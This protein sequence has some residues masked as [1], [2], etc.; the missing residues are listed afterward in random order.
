MTKSTFS[1]ELCDSGDIRTTRSVDKNPTVTSNTLAVHLTYVRHVRLFRAGNS[2]SSFIIVGVAS[3]VSL[4]RRGRSRFRG[5][6]NVADIGMDQ[7]MVFND[8]IS[9]SVYSSYICVYILIL[10]NVI[11]T[12]ILLRS[13]TVGDQAIE[14]TRC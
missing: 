10:Y 14:W 6:V 12:Q 4:V 7:E 8:C 1:L 11:Q 5:P 13:E 2:F 3:L 9:W